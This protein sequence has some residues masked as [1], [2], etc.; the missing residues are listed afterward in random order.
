MTS[1]ATKVH[2]CEGRYPVA[3]VFSVPGSH[4]VT[5]GEPV[6]GVTGENLKYSL[7]HLHAKLPSVFPSI[8]R[9]EYRITNAYSEPIAKSR[10]D[11]SSQASNSQVLEPDNVARVFHELDGCSLVILCGVKAQ[12]LAQAV[13]LSGRTVVCTWHTSNQALSSKFRSAEVS[14]CEEPSGRRRLRAK[15]WAQEL[16]NSIELPLTLPTGE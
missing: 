6:A 5:S 13:L 2:Y 8:E 9:Y 7:K 10:G 15:L 1:D 12:L 4:E 3:F 16:L 11:K 14:A